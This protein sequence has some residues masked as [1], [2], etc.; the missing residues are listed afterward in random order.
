[1]L[2]SLSYQCAIL[3][4]G[5][6]FLL[7]PPQTIADS[8]QLRD[9]CANA[10][11]AVVDHHVSV[12]PHQRTKPLERYVEA[13]SS[14]AGWMA[15]IHTA[16]VHAL[17]QKQGALGI[18]GS[19]GEIGLHH[20]KFFLNL[21]LN[22]AENEEAI[23]I[24]LFDLQS[25]NFDKSGRGRKRMVLRNAERI[26]FNR[27]QFRLLS[28]D[29]TRLAV[30]D[31]QLLNL[32]AFRLFSIDG[33]HSFETTA[34]DLTLARCMMREGG[35]IIV[36]DFIN[37][38]W[39]GVADAV[40]RFIHTQSDVR[41][42]LWLCKKLYLTTVG[43]H[44]AMLRLVQG[45]PCFSCTSAEHLHTSRFTVGSFPLCVARGACGMSALDS[46]TRC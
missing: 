21:L 15:G 38:R 45:I 11:Q 29:S 44:E 6:L 22:K 10:L 43:T 3:L 26:G 12:L 32:S 33:G 5:L 2:S 30:R 42:F 4:Y 41:P 24:D 20:G 36:D 1:M 9:G 34:M 17:S 39:I 37:E 16:V 18:V 7:A 25:R 40:F 8:Q 46:I 28:A 14:M 23:G 13:W 31:F 27:T 35:V 19:V